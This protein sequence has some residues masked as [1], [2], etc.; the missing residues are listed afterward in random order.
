MDIFSV[1][2]T[3]S[4]S[5]KEPK[6]LST[7]VHEFYLTGSFSRVVHLKSRAVDVQIHTF[8]QDHLI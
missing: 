7:A 2:F 4:G 6:S 1:I 3:V 8:N 5:N